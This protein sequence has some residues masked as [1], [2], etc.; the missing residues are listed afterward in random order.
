MNY[1]L[2]IF[3]NNSFVH[4]LGF[5]AAY[6]F[7]ILTID[8]STLID[9][10]KNIAIISRLCDYDCNYTYS[11]IVRLHSRNTFRIH[12]SNE[13]SVCHFFLLVKK[14]Y[15]YYWRNNKHNFRPYFLRKYF[16]GACIFYELLA[17]LKTKQTVTT[18]MAFVRLGL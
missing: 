3:S 16:F 6:S 1:K 4:Q 14:E 17:N 2:N 9:S 12:T 8:T 10:M 11:R 18:K 15:L 13:L 5:K 7:R